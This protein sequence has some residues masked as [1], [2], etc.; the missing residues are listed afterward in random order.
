MMGKRITTLAVL[1]G[2]AI[3]TG[4][5]TF[6]YAEGF[7]YF[8]KAPKACVN[9]HIMTPQYDSWQK[10]SHH[11]AATC[12]DCHLP[13]AFVPKYIAK[14]ENGYH[15]SKGFT[16]EDFHEPIMIKDKNHRI[17]QENCVACHEDMVYELFRRDMTH[18]DAVSCMHCH[19]GVGHG[20]LP[21][22]IGGPDKE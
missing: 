3:G 15:H 6:K 13:H 12:V 18:P 22:S 20:S 8:S 14:A 16:L 4:A 7:S 21:T 19:A 9:C 5:F 2:M 1:F 17:L 11:G 10:S